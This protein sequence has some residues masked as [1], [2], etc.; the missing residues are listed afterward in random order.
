MVCIPD[1]IKCFE[2]VVDV[3]GAPLQYRY[4]SEYGPIDLTEAPPKSRAAQ[5]ALA[6]QLDAFAQAEWDAG[7]DPTHYPPK[8]D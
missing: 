6:K 7:R 8:E 2:V 5:R 1:P 3:A 4:R